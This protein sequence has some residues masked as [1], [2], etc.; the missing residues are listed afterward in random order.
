MV[1]I[2]AIC[3]FNNSD[4]E[5]SHMPLCIELYRRYLIAVNEIS[6]GQKR[7]AR[8][9]GFGE[10]RCLRALTRMI[11]NVVWHCSCQDSLAEMV[12]TKDG[13]R[14]SARIPGAGECKGTADAIPTRCLV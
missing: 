7:L 6:K 13:S 9:M 10:S 3:R 11:C 4:R 14:V 12:H 1:V 8:N 2:R 5:L